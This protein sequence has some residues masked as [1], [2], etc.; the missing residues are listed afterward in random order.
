MSKT[1]TASELFVPADQVRELVTRS[2]VKISVNAKGERQW[3]VKVY[4][5][6]AEVA[7]L[8]A[9]EID[10]SLAKVFG[11]PGRGNGS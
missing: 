8:K 1:Q 4:D 10:A 2:S 5:D 11:L 7:M 9:G 3:E 6:D